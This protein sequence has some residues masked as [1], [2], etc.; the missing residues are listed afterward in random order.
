MD[1]VVKEQDSPPDRVPA[2]RLFDFKAVVH[3]FVHGDSNFSSGG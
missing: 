2:Q 3:F 1:G